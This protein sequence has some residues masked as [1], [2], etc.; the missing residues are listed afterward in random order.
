M[1]VV[2]M[3]PEAADRLVSDSLGW[4]VNYFDVAPFYGDG[5]AEIRLG[6]ALRSCRSGVFLACKTL[7]RGAEGARAELE[8]SL[9]RLQTG[10]FDLYQFHAVASVE[11]VDEI[12]SRSGAIETFTQAREQGLI[13]HIGFSAHSISAALAMIERFEFDS[14]LLPVNV[15]C[16]H[17]GHF[18]PQAL[19]AAKHRGVACIALK[20]LA[21]RKW[22]A[23]EP[24]S[25]P[26]C[27]YRPIDNPERAR[28]AL[29]FTLSQD[30]VAAFPPGDESLFRM[31]VRLALEFAPLSELETAE[32]LASTRG[33][34]LFRS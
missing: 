33:T 22:H 30:V 27:W 12:F 15:G 13:R 6:H 24:R 1:L 26:K 19:A 18:G 9:E 31:A 21:D 28:A 17:L 10:F 5:E 20:A 14:M 29:R 7:E 32:L 8:R 23:R 11:E 34:P 4:G 25:F 2:G 16:W 3:S